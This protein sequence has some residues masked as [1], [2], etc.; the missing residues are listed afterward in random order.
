M[1]IIMIIDFCFFI[2]FHSFPF[3]F[4]PDVDEVFDALRDDRPRRAMTTLLQAVDENGVLEWLQ[5][6]G[7]ELLERGRCIR[8]GSDYTQLAMKSEQKVAEEVRKLTESE[9]LR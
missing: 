1:L 4:F 5:I 9:F 2:V 7:V 3:H 8:L 6:R